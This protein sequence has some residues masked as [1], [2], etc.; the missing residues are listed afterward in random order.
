[1]TVMRRATVSLTHETSVI[2]SAEHQHKLGK[3]IFF[4]FF[5]CKRRPG[6]LIRSHE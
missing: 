6:F 2:M 1:M 5:F 4:F 3:L